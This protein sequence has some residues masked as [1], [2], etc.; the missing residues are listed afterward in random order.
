M[1]TLRTRIFSG[2]STSIAMISLW[3][4]LEDDN[5]NIAISMRAKDKGVLRTGLVLRDR[6]L[7][8]AVQRI[9]SINRSTGDKL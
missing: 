4:S 5:L 9:G 3:L 1:G 7:V 8:D 2:S 6:A